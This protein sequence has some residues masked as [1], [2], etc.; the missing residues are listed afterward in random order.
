MKKILPILFIPMLLTSCGLDSELCQDSNALFPEKDYVSS[1]V[2]KETFNYTVSSTDQTLITNYEDLSDDIKK[3]KNE[4]EFARSTALINES[5]LNNIHYNKLFDG[6]ISCSGAKAN[7]RLG[8]LSNGI[9]V[10]FESKTANEVNG[11]ALYMSHNYLTLKMM[12]T[13]TLYKSTNNPKVTREFN[14]YNFNFRVNLG[15]TNL[16]PY[17]FYVDLNKIFENSDELDNTQMIGFSFERLELTDEEKATRQYMDYISSFEE[18]NKIIDE[19]TGNRQSFVKMYDMALPYA[20]W[21][22]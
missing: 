1:F 18:E 20:T 2:T 4:F 8:L 12:A 11:I 5:G 17:F 19:K 15:T 7:S 21:K 9:I 3:G 10:D 6:E 22:R 16:G 14:A 13:V